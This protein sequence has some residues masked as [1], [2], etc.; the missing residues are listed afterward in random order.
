MPATEVMLYLERI[1]KVSRIC[2]VIEISPGISLDLMTLEVDF[3]RRYYDDRKEL[4]Q[5]RRRRSEVVVEAATTRAELVE[6]APGVV[7]RSPL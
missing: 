6:A 5:S 7:Q 1:E 2:P 3:I 4:Q